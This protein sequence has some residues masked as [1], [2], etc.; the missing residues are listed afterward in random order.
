MIITLLSPFNIRRGHILSTLLL[1]LHWWLQNDSTVVNDQQ[2]CS[3]HKKGAWTYHT[4]QLELRNNQSSMQAIWYWWL[5]RRRR[6]IWLP[7]KSSVQIG[8]VVF[9]WV[10]IFSLP[11]SSVPSKLDALVLGQS[12]LPWLNWTMG[13]VFRIVCVTFRECLWLL[14]AWCGRRMQNATPR[15]AK[16]APTAATT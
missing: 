14:S 8:H 2:L 12:S 13:I 15:I 9:L 1:G 5:H 4:G 6:N 3:C 11:R 16:N 10:S 7:I